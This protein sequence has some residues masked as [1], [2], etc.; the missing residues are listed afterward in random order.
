MRQRGSGS[1]TT[2]ADG[3]KRVRKWVDGRRRSLGIFATDEEAEIVLGAVG[4]ETNETRHREGVTLAQWAERALERREL[5]GLRG[6]DREQSR[7]AMHVAGTELAALPVHGIER[8]DVQR[9]LDR[10]LVKRSRRSKKTLGRQ[11]VAN[12]LTL[13]RAVLEDATAR[14]AAATNPA[15]D[16]HLPRAHGKTH[17]EWTYLTPDEQA[18]LL[19]VVPAHARPAVAFAI[20]AGL[21]QGEQWS[22]PLSDV[23]LDAPSPHVVVRFGAPG[24]PTKS[25]KPRRVDL[26]PEAVAA[27]RAQLELVEHLEHQARRHGKRWNEHRLLFPSLRGS[28][29][30]RGAP[31]GWEAWI[32]RAIGR[33]VRWHDL[34]HT[35]ASS[36]VAGWWGRVWSLREVQALLGHSTVAVTE[37]YAHLAGTITEDAVRATVGTVRGH[38]QGV[39]ARKYWSHLRD[40]NSRPTVYEGGSKSSKVTH[41]T[42]PRGHASPV[43]LARRALAAVG[44]NDPQAGRLL[45]EL[46]G[47][48]LAEEAPKL[49]GREA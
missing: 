14:G 46:A 16:V 5:Q 19:D 39:D 4:L 34:R 22:L 12:A 17:E 44:A 18:R 10:M 13:L 3:R 35:C 36:L 25:G 41:L 31:T 40:L 23:H 7:W 32:E 27:A 49:V 30:Q 28:R 2:T 9:W 45:V 1:V 21:R 29:R 20:F 6:V 38:R 48:V 47:A 33:T 24:K 26:L 8:A 37:R 15:R 43:E 11:T 42:P